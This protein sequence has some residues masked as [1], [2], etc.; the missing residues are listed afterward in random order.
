[1]E[2]EKI[3]RKGRLRAADGRDEG[4]A[5][6][7]R[8]HV[9]TTTPHTTQPT[10]P[11]YFRCLPWLGL[12]LGLGLEVTANAASLALARFPHQLEHALCGA[13]PAPQCYQRR[14]A[15]KRIPQT[16]Y[17]HGSNRNTEPKHHHTTTDTTAVD[18]SLSAAWSSPIFH[19]LASL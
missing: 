10:F 13:Y 15:R 17:T 6:T 11:A 18:W 2:S 5:R 1:M 12:G 19:F 16:A 4:M 8:A 14:V 9:R 3:W 7:V